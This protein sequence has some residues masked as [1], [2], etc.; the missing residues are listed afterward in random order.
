M[1]LLG[2]IIADKDKFERAINGTMS[3]AGEL[4]GGVGEGA[5]DLA[6]IAEYDRLGGLIL[7]GKNKV[8]TGSFYDFKAKKPRTKPE[9]TLTFRVDGEIVDIKDGEGVPLEV[10]ASEQKRERDAKKTADIV[11]KKEE[12]KKKKVKKGADT[13]EEGEDSAADEDEE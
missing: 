8:K 13:E 4:K 6:K 1:E 11:T 5:E 10:Q 12:A 7:K 9:V 2:Y 3:Q